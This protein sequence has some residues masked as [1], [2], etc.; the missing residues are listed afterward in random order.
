MPDDEEINLNG[1]ASVN[2]TLITDC[3]IAGASIFVYLSF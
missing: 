2:Y 1:K 3:R